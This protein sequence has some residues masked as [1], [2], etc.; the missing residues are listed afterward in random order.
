MQGRNYIEARGDNCLLVLWPAQK[1][2]MPSRFHDSNSSP[3]CT[4]DRY[5][6]TKNGK[7]FWGRGIAPFPNPSPSGEGD[8]P[9]LHPT[10]LGAF[11]ASIVAPTALPP[12]RLRRH[13]SRLWRSITQCLLVFVSLVT[14]LL[15][16]N[17]TSPTTPKIHNVS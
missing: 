17:M 10:T 11:G 4:K 13:H 5:F 15:W 9:S 6:E 16:E 12:R 2:C 14:A 3:E 7:I 1:R 8:T